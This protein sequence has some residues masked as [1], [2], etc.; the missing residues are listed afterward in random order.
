MAIG[1]EYHLRIAASEFL[2]PRS[3]GITIFAINAAVVKV[4][5]A[6]EG[7]KYNILSTRVFISNA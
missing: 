6:A 7:G 3:R 1:K 2:L 4:Y 5:T